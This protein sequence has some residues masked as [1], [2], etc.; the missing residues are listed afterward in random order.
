MML[1]NELSFK[2]LIERF[3]RIGVAYSGGLDSTVLLHAISQETA[4]KNKINAI[5]INH[6]ISPD[7]DKWEEF[8]RKNADELGVQFFSYKVSRYINIFV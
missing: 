1:L 8:C 6:S 2:A 3:D 4:L 5:H 7:S